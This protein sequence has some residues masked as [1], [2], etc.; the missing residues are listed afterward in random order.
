MDPTIYWI[1]W[2]KIG[3]IFRI[4]FLCPK[5]YLLFIMFWFIILYLT[6]SIHYVCF[7]ILNKFY[8]LIFGHLFCI[9]LDFTSFY[10]ALHSSLPCFSLG[11][12]LAEPFKKMELASIQPSRTSIELKQLILTQYHITWILHLH[13]DSASTCIV[14]LWRN[15]VS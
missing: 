2:N 4:F 14:V 8:L 5:N 1:F 12:S 15:N 7:I 11:L 3:N 6:L 10:Y 13:S 9:L